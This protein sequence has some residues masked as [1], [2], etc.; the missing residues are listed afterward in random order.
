M[1]ES[2]KLLRS[3]T[4][5]SIEAHFSKNSEDFVV[6][7]VPLYEFSG[8]GE[9]LI[10]HI[11]KKDLSTPEALQI[12]SEQ[13]GA[14]IKDFGYAG[15]K[16]KQ[17][18][19]FQ[20]ISIHKKFEPNL[21]KFSHEKMQI[22]DMTYHNNKLKIGHLKGNSFFVRLKKVDS[23]NAKKLQ[24]AFELLC[25]RGFANYFGLQR[26]GKFKDNF[27]NALELLQGKKMKNSRIKEFLFSAFQ[28]ELFNRYLA[29][30][31]QLSHFVKDFSL[32]EFAK[33]YHISK[34]E[35]KQIYKQEN[36][37]KLLR[38]EVLAHYPYGKVFLCED[39]EAESSR[40]IKKELSPSG[41]LLGAKAYEC[42]ELSFAKTLENEIFKDFYLYKERLNGSRRYLWSFV[43]Q[44]KCEYDE[45]KAHFKL[46]FFLQKGSYATII[47]HELLG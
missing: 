10:L 40:F 37:F 16:D 20:Y 44:G 31:V 33:I 15:L 6:R 36:F 41:L 43:E 38:G 23:L 4:H 5:S 30:R 12:L 29:K 42:E 3:L 45:E 17:G 14:K 22:L 25:E 2:K 1:F 8:S 24:N 21:R 26:F 9:H 35:A 27:E 13:S 28:S 18:K 32:S 46:E 11:S 47:L 39:L 7:E 34:D 19:T